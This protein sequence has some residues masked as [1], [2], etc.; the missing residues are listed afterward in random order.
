[1]NNIFFFQTQQIP[2]NTSLF[3]QLKEQKIFFSYFQVDQNHYL[4]LFSQPNIQIDF[5]YP[6]LEVIDELNYKQRRIRSF[7][8]FFLYALEIIQ[9]AQDY[10]ILQTNLQPFFWRKIKNIIRQNKKGALLEFL[11]GGE[12][13][14]MESANGRGDSFKSLSPG[15]DAKIQT[16]Q[17][18]VDS[19]AQQVEKLQ[20]KVIQL[21]VRVEQNSKDLLSDTLNA[22]N[23]IKITQNYTLRGKKALYLTENESEVRNPTYQTKDIESKTVSEASISLLKPLSNTQQYNLSSNQEK[24][25]NGS[26]FITLSKIPEE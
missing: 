22:P 4:F 17:N 7:R 16:L 26:N 3:N 25:L 8:G 24:G 21:E 2:D 20:Q 5:L 11:F 10:E 14:R 12:V 9:K 6:F 13:T 18:Q 23:D 1:M 15:L 19:L